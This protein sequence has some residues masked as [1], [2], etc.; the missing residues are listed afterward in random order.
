MMTVHKSL[1]IKIE[2]KRKKIASEIKTLDPRNRQ[3]ATEER[4]SP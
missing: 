2:K 4:Q 1:L 3:K